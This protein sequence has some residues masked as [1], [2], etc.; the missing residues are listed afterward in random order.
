[1][2][3]WRGSPRRTEAFERSALLDSCCFSALGAGSLASTRLKLPE[4]PALN[5]AAQL[6]PTGVLLGG[7]VAVADVARQTSLS[8]IPLR[9]WA[10]LAFLTVA[11]TL[12]GYAM[13]LMLSLKTSPA[14]ANTF[15]YVAPVIALLLSAWLLKEPLG[16]EKLISAGVT[17]TGVALM[18]GGWE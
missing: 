9:A 5:L 14:L 8:A 13:F 12:V 2:Y 11:S 16:W 10:A 1:M 7:W 15:N 3:L 18:V 17:L 4:D 6:V